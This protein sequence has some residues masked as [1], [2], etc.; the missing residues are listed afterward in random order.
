[1]VTLNTTADLAKLPEIREHVLNEANAAGL[2]DPMQPKLDLV[3]EEI[4]VNVTNHAY[5]GKS[6][7]VEIDCFTR[8]DFFCVTVRDWGTAFDPLSVD[9]SNLPTDIDLRKIGGVGLL[10]VTTMSDS[11]TYERK[12]D[13]NELTFCL[14]L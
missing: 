12:N 8:S 1:M 2:S 11:C 13:A 3:L 4:L 7:K 10:L 6:G 5:S 14:S 9:E